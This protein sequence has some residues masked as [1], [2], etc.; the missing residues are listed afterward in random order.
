MLMHMNSSTYH[1]PARMQVADPRHQ[2]SLPFLKA[3]GEHGEWH[4]LSTMLDYGSVEEQLRAYRPSTVVHMQVANDAARDT[5]N[6]YKERLVEYADVLERVYGQQQP[7]LVWITSATRH[8]KAGN[9][10]GAANCLG[11]TVESCRSVSSGTSYAGNGRPHDAVVWRYEKAAPPFFYGTLDR[12]R[13]FNAWAVMYMRSRF[14]A[15]EVLDFE[16]EATA[17]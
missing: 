11:G 15:L 13:A 8:Y 16:V 17:S 3:E 12:R 10:P 7:R 4:G 5:F 6:R 9:G 14:P 2:F 1:W